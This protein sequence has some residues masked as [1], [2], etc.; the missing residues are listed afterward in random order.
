LQAIA[1]KT[2]TDAMFKRS[3]EIQTVPIDNGDTA[4]A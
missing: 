3:R 1:N 2:I 4:M